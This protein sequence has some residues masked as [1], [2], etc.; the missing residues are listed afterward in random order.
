MTHIKIL[1]NKLEYLPAQYPNIFY[2]EYLQRLLIVG[3]KTLNN[4]TNVLQTVRSGRR[5]FRRFTDY[6]SDD[7]H[8]GSNKSMVRPLIFR[9]VFGGQSLFKSQCV[10]VI[11]SQYIKLP[12]PITQFNH[13]N[14]LMVY[15]IKRNFQN[16]GYFFFCLYGYVL[17]F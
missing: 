13:D 9:L 2:I 7:Y 5:A 8:I 3:L 15:K 1:V 6:G 12:H 4:Y 16:K 17:F 10:D 14:Y 11:L